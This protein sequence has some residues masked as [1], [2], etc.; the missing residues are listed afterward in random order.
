MILVT[1]P[2]GSNGTVVIKALLE[3]SLQVKALVR[4]D[5]DQDEIRKNAGE[6]GK[7]LAFAQGD[8]DDKESLVRA[9]EDCDGL[10]VMVPFN[11]NMERW[12]NNLVDAAGKSGIGHVVMFS[13]LGADASS[14]VRFLAAHGASD[15]L[16]L[17]SGLPFTTVR[18]NDLMQNY[19]VKPDTVREEGAMYSGA[20]DGRI[21]WVDLDD[22]AE[23]IAA[24]FADPAAH[25][26]M[27]YDL[28][29]PRAITIDDFAAAMTKVLGRPFRH[30]RI[31]AE[32]F[33][34]ISGE[35]RGNTWFGEGVT[36]IMH[37]IRNGWPSA[38]VTPN[39]RLLTGHEPTNV[40]EFIEKNRNALS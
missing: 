33:G 38:Y 2:G 6:Q 30:E 31:S 1:S 7:Y 9:L 25:S 12:Q 8:F 21:S 36:E 34:E 4:A 35:G 10:L 24:I 32:A 37:W 40:E 18:A 27:T 17:A 14:P 11:E 20:E 15:K 16:L 19:L 29:G 23:A 39:I 3:R 26:G 28:T 22:V 13:E 5:S